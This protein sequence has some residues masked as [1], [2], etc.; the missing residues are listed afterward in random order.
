MA[1]NI[2]LVTV[3]PTNND[4]NNSLVMYQDEILG[5][6]TTYKD[7]QGNI[8]PLYIAGCDTDAVPLDASYIVD[9]DSPDGCYSYIQ[10][11]TLVEFIDML[12][13]IEIICKGKRI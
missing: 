3:I 6:K 2:D 12:N 9:E 13:E 4:A 8:L 10:C 11:H 7:Q 1:Y 5:T